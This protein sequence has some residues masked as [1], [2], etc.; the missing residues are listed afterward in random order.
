MQ[1]RLVLPLP[2]SVN[3]LVTYSPSGSLVKRHDVVRW[4]RDAMLLA[5]VWR[6][7]A[8]WVPT[9]RE[10]VIVRLWTYWPDGTYRDTHNLYKVLF[11][12]LQGV[13]YDNDYWVLP[14]QQDFI[15]D[16]NQPRLELTLSRF[17]EEVLTHDTT[18]SD[19]ES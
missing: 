14:R 13:L 9:V 5:R 18:L 19:V 1:P 10:K 15:V 8:Q 16:R 4:S 6:R 11:D 2:R 3:S 7:T 12:A 17:S